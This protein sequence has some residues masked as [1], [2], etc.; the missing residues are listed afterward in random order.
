MGRSDSVF[1]IR[2]AELGHSV[3]SSNATTGVEFSDVAA[4]RVDG[5]GDV[6][7]LVQAVHGPIP[8]SFWKLE[9]V[10]LV[11]AV[12]ARG[13]GREVCLGW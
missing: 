8:A 2:A 1:N 3:E 12:A 4:D 7:T 11:N 6:V 10:A 13:K 5:A 9:G